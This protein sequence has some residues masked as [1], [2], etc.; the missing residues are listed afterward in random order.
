MSQIPKRNV[1]RNIITELETEYSNHRYGF[2]PFFRFATYLSFKGNAMRKC[3]SA[4]IKGNDARMTPMFVN[5]NR[6][7]GVG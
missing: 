7:T 2:I 5:V 1:I 4:D 6:T 3:A